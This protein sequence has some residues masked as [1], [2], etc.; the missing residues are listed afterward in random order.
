[1]SVTGAGGLSLTPT[2]TY[3]N[4]THVG[5]A[6]ASYTYSGDSNHYGGSDTKTF[7]ITTAF[8]IIGFDNPVDMTVVGSDRN[9]NSVKNGQT[10]PLKFRVFNLDGTEVTTTAGLSAMARNVDCASGDVDATL[11]PID[12]TNSAGLMRTGDRFHFNW[13]VPKGA[14]KCYQ[15]VIKTADGSTAMS[16]TM[17]GT[18]VVEAYFK[19]K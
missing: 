12:A 10:V 14:G 13:A 5:T 17:A 8:R 4:N 11:L 19:S 1:V 16:L 6:T 9:Y 2:A 3:S 7:L 18:P 15:I